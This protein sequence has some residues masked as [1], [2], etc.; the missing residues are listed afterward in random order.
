MPELSYPVIPAHKEELRRYVQGVYGGTITEV[1]TK[2]NFLKKMWGAMSSLVHHSKSN[3][4]VQHAVRMY[5][6][7]TCRAYVIL[8]IR[9]GSFGY[10]PV[11]HAVLMD[12][13]D[14][15]DKDIDEV[16]LDACAYARSSHPNSFFPELFQLREMIS[17]VYGGKHFDISV[18][19]ST[20]HHAFVLIANNCP[21]LFLEKISPET[22]YGHMQVL[23]RKMDEIHS[24]IASSQ[25]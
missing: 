12:F 25:K 19:P 23:A 16:E 20:P 22:V 2:E 13:I 9:Y 17:T 21:E 1:L 15:L 10:Q 14:M 24:Q 11:M 6:N 5:P 8:S 18:L 3:L 4:L 7:L